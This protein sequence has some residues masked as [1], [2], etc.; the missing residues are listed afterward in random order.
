MFANESYRILSDRFENVSNESVSLKAMFTHSQS[1][2][3][4]VDLLVTHY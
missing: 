2:W 4:P 3:N 1:P